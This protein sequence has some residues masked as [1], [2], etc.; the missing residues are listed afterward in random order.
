VSHFSTVE[1]GPFW[2]LAL[3]VLLSQGVWYVVIFILCDSSIS[4][5]VIASVLASVVWCPGARYVHGHLD[6][7][8]C[9]VGGGGGV[10]IWP[11]L[12]LLGTS[13]PCPWSELI[14][15]LSECAIEP[16]WVGDAS[17]GPDEFD[18]LLSFGDVDRFRLVLVIVLWEWVPD[19]FFQYA[20]G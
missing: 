2:A 20:W 9:R 19:D 16:P 12:I 3:V 7:I 13:P 5:G 1:A 17:S 10:V 8:I 18:H 6:V 15:I 14:L 4:V 11:L